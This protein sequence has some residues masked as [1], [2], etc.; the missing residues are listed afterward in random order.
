M[1]KSVCVLGGGPA[2]LSTTLALAKQGVDVCLL[3]ASDYSQRRS[4]EH[5]AA[6]GRVLLDRLSLPHSLIDDN[7]VP[8]FSVQSCWGDE[9]MHSSESIFGVYGEGLLLSRPDFDRALAQLAHDRDVQVSLGARVHNINRCGDG[10]KINY[11]QGAQKKQV[12]ARFVIDAS[13]RN[14][15]C[16]SCVGARKVQYDRLIGIS[17]CY[18]PAIQPMDK[19][20]IRIEAAAHGWWYATLLRDN[21]LVLTYMTDVD[22]LKFLDPRKQQAYAV[23]E[24][25]IHKKYGLGATDMIA[26]RYVASAKTQLLSKVAGDGWMAVGDA[27]WS[28]DPLSSL[29]IVKALDSAQQAAQQTITYLSG[30]TPAL[31]SYVDNTRKTFLDYLSQRSKYYRME[32]RWENNLFWQRRHRPTWLELPI[33]IDPTDKIK[34]NDESGRFGEHLNL[35]PGIDLGVLLPIMRTSTAVADA[36]IRYRQKH[37]DGYEDKELI[38]AIQTILHPELLVS[39]WHN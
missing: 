29:G 11:R 23:I 3:E 1:N 16:A 33:Q 14:T 7:S 27:A 34:L 12:E 28:A 19:G 24:A 26:P 38:I 2:G 35:T 20:T 36:A 4:G 21:T 25:E 15:R 13:G 18:R 31:E 39:P 9:E 17:Y 8:C 6:Q 22:C 32:S 37:V 5:V 30:S 10:W